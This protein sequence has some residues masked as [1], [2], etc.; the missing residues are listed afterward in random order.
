RFSLPR[1]QKLSISTIPQAEMQHR[2]TDEI[3][4]RVSNARLTLPLSHLCG[5]VE[6]E[7]NCWRKEI[8]AHVPRQT[9]KSHS[10]GH[11]FDPVQL[12]HID[13]LTYAPMPSARFA[14]GT[15]WAPTRVTASPGL[16]ES[17]FAVDLF[18]RCGRILGEDR[19]FGATRTSVFSQIVAERSGFA[20]SAGARNV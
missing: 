8:S 16:P 4:V 3:T 14:L 10:G 9:R 5:Q 1:M 12:H 13:S 17:E 6:T 11:R 7:V 18:L 19:V 15:R 20:G 2:Y